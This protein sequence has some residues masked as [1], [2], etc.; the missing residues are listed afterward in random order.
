MKTI[1]IFLILTVASLSQTNVR[2]WYRNGQVWIVWQE[3]GVR[4]QT[5]AIYSS[6][7]LFTN[8]NQAILIGRLFFEEWSGFDL[9]NNANDSTVRYRV[10]LP[11]SGFDTLESNEGLFVETVVATGT[12]YYAVIKYGDT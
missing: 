11:G 8:T 1:M 12:R 2:G 5:Y 4:P 10:P 3:T 7:N 6:P 9:K